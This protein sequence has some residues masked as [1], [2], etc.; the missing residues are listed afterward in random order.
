MSLSKGTKFSVKIE[1]NEGY[2]AKKHSLPN[3]LVL[4]HTDSRELITLINE[5][6]I[7]NL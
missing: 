6:K 7:K 2:T 5:Q 4:K 1:T 3:S